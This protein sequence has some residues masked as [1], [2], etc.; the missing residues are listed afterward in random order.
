MISSSSGWAS[1][2]QSS[3]CN[4]DRLTG[5]YPLFNHFLTKDFHTQHRVQTTDTS[6]WDTYRHDLL[7]VIQGGC[8]HAD[9]SILVTW[10]S[11]WSEELPLMVNTH[12]GQKSAKLQSRHISPKHSSWEWSSTS[13]SMKWRS[14]QQLHRAAN[15]T[16]LLMLQVS[17]LPETDNIKYMMS[18]CVLWTD[19]MPD[20]FF[21]ISVSAAALKVLSRCVRREQTHVPV[22]VEGEVD[23]QSDAVVNG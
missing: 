5:H 16:E 15:C 11:R 20:V 19:I 6:S 18:R 21:K 8:R 14:L 1:S 17:E 23:V 9:N 7:Q 3:F 12:S 10:C 22:T 13:E 4:N 2:R